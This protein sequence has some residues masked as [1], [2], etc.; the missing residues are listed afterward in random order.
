MAFRGVSFIYILYK[1]IFPEVAAVDVEDRSQDV[2]REDAS[3]DI[4]RLNQLDSGPVTRISTWR[5]PSKGEVKGPGDVHGIASG[6]EPS[7]ALRH[8]A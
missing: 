3:I 5:A 1:N 2:A 8:D 7:P 4:F 6:E